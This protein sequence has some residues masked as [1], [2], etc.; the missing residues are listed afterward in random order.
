M[1]KWLLLIICFYSISTFGQN[2]QAAAAPTAKPDE[3]APLDIVINQVKAALD[4]Y[5][6]NRGAG[7]D[8][9]P[10]LSSAEFD[11]KT[12]TATT[13]G[14]TVNLF[15]FK[16]GG[17]HESDVVNDVTY[18]Y[19]VP[20]PPPPPTGLTSNKKPPSLKDALAQ[21]IQSAALA[22]KTSGNLGKLSFNKLTV[23]ISYGVKWDGNI[24]AN[25]P[26]QFVTVGLNAD[27]NKN[28]VQSVKL[29]FGQ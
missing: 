20:K 15:I 5:Q 10:A 28:T 2:A 17:S 3:V 8:S 4:E 25:I 21:T 29:V 14:A 1:S 6:K 11:F 26:I 22:V 7:G 23:N 27:K 18:T 9:L 13:F 12:T 24:G 19:A 16:L